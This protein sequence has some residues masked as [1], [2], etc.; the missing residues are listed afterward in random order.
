MQTQAKQFIQVDRKI[1]RATAYTSP[2]TGLPVKFDHNMKAVYNLMFDRWQLFKSLNMEH[3]DTQD[4]IATETAI[5][6][7]TVNKIITDFINNGVFKVYSLRSPH[8]HKKLIYKTINTLQ[9]IE[10]A[11]EVAVEVAESV[12]KQ[13]A[14]Q[15][16]KP[17]TQRPTPTAEVVQIKTEARTERPVKAP[18]EAPVKDAAKAP[19]Q[20]QPAHDPRRISRS[21]CD[22]DG[23]RF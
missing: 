3:F 14:K 20:Q 13:P 1:T 23:F 5:S 11:V 10:P 18:I 15:P 22:K 21:P 8:G 16:T 9:L 2:V 19:D 7:R 6:L 4:Y 17:A 12:F